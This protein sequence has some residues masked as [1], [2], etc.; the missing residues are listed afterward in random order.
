ML[1]A[2]EHDVRAP[3]QTPTLSAHESSSRPHSFTPV[4]M[5]PP[6]L[7]QNAPLPFSATHRRHSLT[8]ARQ[9]KLH[10]N[11]QLPRGDSFRIFGHSSSASAPAA[12]PALSRRHSLSPIT[13]KPLRSSPLA[14]P[15]FSSEGQPPEE[16]A[17]MGSLPPRISSSPDLL[18]LSRRKAAFVSHNPT[19]PRL[20]KRASFIE[21]VKRPLVHHIKAKE[22]PSAPLPPTPILVPQPV[23]PPALPARSSARPAPITLTSPVPHT[24]LPAPP[25]SPRRRTRV[26]QS[27][28]SSSL[29][30]S[31]A[32]F[33]APP[34]NFPRAL[35]RD[36]LPAL[37]RSSPPPSISGV[38]DGSWLPSPP[39]GETPRFSRL[40]LAAPNVVL[41]MSAREHRQRCGATPADDG[42]VRPPAYPYLY[43][44]SAPHTT[45][46][47]TF[48]QSTN[49][50]MPSLL[51]SQRRSM[52]PSSDGPDTPSAASSEFG[53]SDNVHLDNELGGS[54]STWSLS[55]GRLR[56]CDGQKRTHRRTHAKGISFL[57][58]GS[59]S[60]CHTHSPSLSEEQP[61]P[62]LRAPVEV[63]MSV[64][65]PSKLGAGASGTV[66]RILRSLSSGVGRRRQNT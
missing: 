58:F 3:H 51:P 5:A 36:S 33:P 53:G 15:A 28:V 14:G 24:P 49:E 2:L 41:P 17:A 47:T 26:R 9:P 43:P 4:S 31:L 48:L 50:S 13:R 35:S 34:P 19:A 25:P 38:A 62:P 16:V 57:S 18:S 40:S 66:R 11:S 55:I 12:S 37:S 21:L 45:G 52:S 65:K 46:S 20:S 60:T 64:V 6:S 44:Q 7:S 59:D 56:E 39:F 61:A 63:A 22:P 27:S 1:V 42:L 23:P 29:S 30:V 54:D 8:S 10:T 32:A